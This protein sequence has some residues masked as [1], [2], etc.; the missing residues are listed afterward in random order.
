M[1]SAVSPF[2]AFAL[3]VL[4]GAILSIML[5]PFLFS[6]VPRPVPAPEPAAREPA[7][8]AP[9]H[10]VLVGYGRVGRDI[11]AG[12]RKQGR[13]F[14]I[15]EAQPDIAREA[16]AAGLEVVGGNA[17][18]AEVL[19][20]AG[21]NRA[22]KLVIA[23]PGG[24]EAGAIVEKAHRLVPELPII[25]R[26]HADEEVAH[27]ER[28]G[29]QQVVMAERVAAARILQLATPGLEQRRKQ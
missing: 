8:P 27:L 3:T 9:G 18:D 4:A 16:A 12:L 7:P 25:A 17:A 28:L 23:I 14:T 10:V 20:E 19:L 21:L 5:N 29:A 15:V 22:A 2:I 1:F 13:A 24:F 26:A 11:A 6:L